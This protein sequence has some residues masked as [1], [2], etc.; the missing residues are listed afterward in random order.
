MRSLRR[1]CLV[2]RL[3]CLALC[4]LGA[5]APYAPLAADEP[6][7]K[8]RYQG[9]TLDQWRD[10]IKSLD[11]QS[12]EAAAAVSGLLEIALDP[13]APWF[14]RRQAALTLG[15]IGPSA[16]AAVPQLEQLIQGPATDDTAP[17]LWAMKA[18][19]LFGPVAAPAT[20]AISQLALSPGT[21]P[22]LQLLSIEA[23]CRI[24]L[25]HPQTLPTV[26]ALLQQDQPLLSP[27]RMRSGVELDRV[28]AAIQCLEL[29]GSGGAD[30]VPVLLRYSEDREERV[31]RAVAVTL[32]AF[33][34]RGN[35]AAQRLAEIVVTDQSLD[36][37]D[38]AAISLGQVGVTEWLGRLIRHPDAATRE[39]ACVGLGYSSPSD[40]TAQE[41]LAEAERDQ[42]STVRMAAIEA[43]QRLTKDSRRTAPA[44]ARELAS[45]ER[46]VRLRAIRFLTQL[47]PKAAPAREQLEQLTHHTDSQVSRSATRL[48]ESLLP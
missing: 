1:V 44:A 13:A 22:H 8:A 7:V 28:V 9:W 5:Q 6:Q 27:A 32:G 42:S 47:G 36:V 20:P 35:D 37:R 25:A 34:P 16:A 26:I 2:C 38:V 18:L 48:L 10:R 11:P 29:F 23:L 30:A 46:S 43:L 15:R 12:P 41:L 4:L 14:T 21:E 40:N 17:A 31:R 45:E 39:R 33:G 24:G 3:G 19:A